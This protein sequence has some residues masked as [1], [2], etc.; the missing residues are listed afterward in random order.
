MYM[1]LHFGCSTANNPKIEAKASLKLLEIL[2]FPRWLASVRPPAFVCFVFGD[3][4]RG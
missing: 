4:D 3:S 1:A 2:C